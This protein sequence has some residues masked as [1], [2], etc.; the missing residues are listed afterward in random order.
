MQPSGKS[1]GKAD[2]TPGTLPGCSFFIL[3]RIYSSRDGEMSP[4]KEVPS[5]GA[6]SVSA[7]LLPAGCRSNP[8]PDGNPCI[9]TKIPGEERERKPAPL[10]S[11]GIFI[12]P[13]QRGSTSSLIAVRSS[14]SIVMSMNAGTHTRSMPWGATK[15]R[16]IAMAFTA[17]FRAPA[18]IAWISALPFSLKTPAKAPATEFGLDFVDTFS[19][20]IFVP[21]LKK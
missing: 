17:W 10:P 4:L 14:P 21:P 7:P 11:P 15:P 13:D 1:S 16:A 2:G 6:K 3:E 5:S 20:S 18:P 12:F 19:T 8:I 9:N